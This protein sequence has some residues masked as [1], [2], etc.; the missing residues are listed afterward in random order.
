[1]KLIRIIKKED[2][3]VVDVEKS[4]K[5]FGLKLLTK[6]QEYRTNGVDW[7]TPSGHKK[8]PKR[9]KRQLDRWLQEHKKYF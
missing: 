3:F 7:V 8:L 6:Q 4:F 1:M 9:K 5:L 2:S